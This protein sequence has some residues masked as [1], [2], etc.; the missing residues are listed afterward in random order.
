MSKRKHPSGPDLFEWA[1]RRPTQNTEPEQ[2]APLEEKRVSATIIDRISFFRQRKKFFLAIFYRD[3][4]A[5]L[6]PVSGDVLRLDDF[7][8]P[9]HVPTEVAPTNLLREGVDMTGGI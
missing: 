3:E 6:R 5:L 8:A 2:P 7:R 9:K 1:A 4:T